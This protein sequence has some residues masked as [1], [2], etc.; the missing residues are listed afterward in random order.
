MHVW[1]TSEWYN[2]KH[3]SAARFNEALDSTQWFDD[4]EY[5]RRNISFDGCWLVLFGYSSF[6][7]GVS[8]AGNSQEAKFEA[9]NLFNH[10]AR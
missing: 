3:D 7:R 5:K 10:I 2:E 8:S 6:Q 4:C 9:S 1:K